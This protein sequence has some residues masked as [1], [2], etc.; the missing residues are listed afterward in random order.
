MDEKNKPWPAEVSLKKEIWRSMLAL[1]DSLEKFTTWSLAGVGATTALLLTNVDKLLPALSR[2][3][4]K[5]GM[6]LFL[7]SLVFGVASKSI[8][9]ALQS[10]LATTKLVEDLFLSVEG[11]ALMAQTETPMPKFYQ[12]I[13]DPFRWWRKPTSADQARSN[14]LDPLAA[15]KRLIKMFNSQHK[16]F[17]AH[18]VLAGMAIIVLGCAF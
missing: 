9:M 4:Y 15:E 16:W 13:N 18:L 10:A 6:L 12:E 11:R 7:L 5:V 17:T 14:M 3:L 8:G 2:G 1:G